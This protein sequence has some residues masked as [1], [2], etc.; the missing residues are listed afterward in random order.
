MAIFSI[1]YPWVPSV[2][3]FFHIAFFLFWSLN[4]RA[5]IQKALGSMTYKGHFICGLI[6]LCL[7][8]TVHEWSICKIVFFFHLWSLKTAIHTELRGKKACCDHGKTQHNLYVISPSFA[9]MHECL[10]S[11][12][13]QWC[14]TLWDP[15][16][17]NSPGFSVHGILQARILEWVAIFFSR[18]SSQ[19]RNRTWVS[20]IADRHFNLW[21]TREAGDYLKW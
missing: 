14:P 2:Y 16:D 9:K 20:C 19:P 15:M 13:A 1:L 12:V 8:Q 17:C 11:E 7:G 5:Y 6:C 21:A 4:F 18:G 10:V 3:V